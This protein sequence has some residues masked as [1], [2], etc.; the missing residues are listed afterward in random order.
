MADR[1]KALFISNISHELRSP[2]HGIL[3]SAEF[4]S[5]TPLDTLQRTFIDTIDSCA[6]T[7]LEVI[8]QVLEFGKLTYIERIKNKVS[9][10]HIQRTSSKDAVPPAVNLPPVDLMAIAEQVVESCYAGHEFKGI[11]G[12]TDAGS[13]AAEQKNDRKSITHGFGR[14]KDPT[15]ALTVVIDVDYRDQ[16]WFFLLQTGPFQ[17]ILMNITGNA[18]KYTSKGW[19]RVY[20]TSSNTGGQQQVHMIVSDSGKGISP[21][22]LKTRLFSPFSQEDALQTGTGLGMSIVKQF[23][24]RLGGQ[25]HVTSQV[26]VGT[27]VHVTLP[28]TVSERPAGPDIC[29]RVRSLTK[30]MKVFLAGFDKNVPASRLLYESMAHYLTNWYN[31]QLVDDVYSSDLIVSD[32]CPELHDYFQQRSPSDYYAF[33][34][35][36]SNSPQPLATPS[37]TQSV[38]RA[39][40]PLIVLCSN[41]LRYELFGQQAETG[42]IIDFSSKPC[43]PYKLARS[44]LFCLEQAE[45]RSRSM[46]TMMDHMQINSPRRGPSRTPSS[47]SASTED[48]SPI[49]ESGQ[50]HGRRGSLGKGAVR[51]S[52]SV[53]RGSTDLG[54]SMYVPGKGFV[55][56]QT[57]SI[58]EPHRFVGVRRKSSHPNSLS[59]NSEDGGVANGVTEIDPSLKMPTVHHRPPT[60]E[61]HR[62]E[63][64]SDAPTAANG[65]SPPS[66]YNRRNPPRS[67][68]I[69]SPNIPPMQVGKGTPSIRVPQVLIVEDNSVNAMIL[70]TFLRKRGYPFAQAENGLLAVQAVQ[71]RPEGFDVILMD[72]QSI[73]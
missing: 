69:T 36:F 49:S 31:M 56:T 51:F 72:I 33:G 30:D 17:R 45:S 25:I 58:V 9:R 22:F 10:P 13:L 53:R 27:K 19:V 57:S 7:L 35:P 28:A 64:K 37:I 70:A 24:D 1:A 18:L 34:S 66:L 59:T 23:V 63:Q 29:A 67:V 48:L 2:L 42:K 54:A 8:N 15:S 62:A 60:P 6:R 55:P 12:P 41:A 68:S 43:G 38:Y 4:L 21:E 73:F 14:A 26:S 52:P 47:I 61:N 46:D 16:G 71:A 44:L 5:D 65:G 39:W 20:L 32:E 50:P 11:F 40:Q 3:A